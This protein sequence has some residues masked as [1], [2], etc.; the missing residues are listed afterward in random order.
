MVQPRGARTAAIGSLVIA[1][2]AVG[3]CGDTS[4]QPA[5]EQVPSSSPASHP[6]SES[7]MSTTT[8]SAVTTSTAA[9]AF[10]TA[11]PPTS[12]TI[13]PV[14]LVDGRVYGIGRGTP[15]GDAVDVLGVDPVAASALD[16]TAIQRACTGLSESWVIQ[17][18]GLTLFFEGS[19]AE[20]AWLT[21]W[22]YSGG[23][24]AGSTELVTST[25]IRVGDSRQDILAAHTGVSDL[26]TEIDVVHPSPLRYGLDGDTVTWFGVIDCATEI[27]PPA[28]D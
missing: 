15:L 28:D 23:P 20:D 2:A 5:L 14:Q 10:T 18:G 8:T 26:G 4:D 9:T 6:R 16:P 17:S 1:I 22:W 24:I 12:T 21:N 11:A 25:G 19:S 13:G 3:G 7:S 27:E